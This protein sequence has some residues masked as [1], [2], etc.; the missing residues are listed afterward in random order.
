M[1][2]LLTGSRPYL[3]LTVLCL[4]LYLP[5]LS[6]VPPLDRDEARFAQASTQ[7][8]ETGDY[9]SINFQ[10]QAR[11]KKPVGIYWL[12]AGAVELLSHPAAKQIW[13]Y[14]VPSVVGAWAA[15]LLTFYFG[16]FF[17]GRR[18]A[19]VGAGL[20]G[21]SLM[22]VVEAHLAKTDAVLLACTV[23]AMGALGR[24][25]L[26]AKG[27]QE[28]P[29][30]WVALVFWLALGCGILVKGPIVPLIVL[31]AYIALG[32]LDKQWGWVLRMKL[33]TGAIIVFALVA[34]WFAAIS[35]TDTNF[36]GD[37]LQ[38]D[39]LSKIMGGQE[40][41]GGWPGYYLL[42]VNLTLWPASLFLWP[43]LWRAWKKRDEPQPRFLLAWIVPMW[44]VFEA[45]PTKLPHYTLPMYPALALLIAAALFA[46]KDLTYTRFLGHAASKVYAVVWGLLGA[47]LAGALLWAPTEYGF[48]FEIWAVPA[49]LGAVGAV[50]FGLWHFWQ[51]RFLPAAFAAVMGAALTFVVTYQNVMP[52]LERLWLSPRIAEAVERL[53]PNAPAPPAVAEY[54]E[55]SLVFLLGTDTELLDGGGVARHILAHP[56]AVGVV[57]GREEESFQAALAQAGGEAE[58]LGGLDG[59]NYS[60]GRETTVTLYRAQGSGAE[61]PR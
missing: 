45:V 60:R 40:R 1:H 37:A 17:Y 39:F 25:Y 19:F 10:D 9:I 44:I 7:M 8:M 32:I 24:Y 43:S 2:Q 6:A 13:A 50:G 46:V 54:H 48:G 55:P 3:I 36:V 28:Q 14:R 18:V 59:F 4:L 41:H 47:A 49:A 11:N 12:Q 31:F 21:A 53:A 16:S 42:L 52:G 20:L 27:A 26:A 5:G 56:G 34:P 23:A 58:L 22:L 15:V 57:G 61:E 38:K 33:I 51:N 29:K 35:A 30:D